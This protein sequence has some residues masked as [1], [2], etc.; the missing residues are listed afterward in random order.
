MGPQEYLTAPAPS[1]T[2][3]RVLCVA[4]AVSLASCSLSPFGSHPA[5]FPPLEPGKGRVLLYRSSSSVSSYVSEALLNGERVGRA[6][7]KGVVYRD[8]APG[9]YAV[10]T[11]MT[12]RVV[13]F[14]VAAGER[15]YVRFS[16]AFFDS[17]IYP[18]LVEASKGE[19]ETAS[20]E[21]LDP[22]RTV[23]PKLP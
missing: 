15:K 2:M 14:S 18:E 16:N 22:P 12:A 17:R 10:T 21:R 6:D 20:L 1:A 11:T 9:S 8:V 4:A 13:N 3:L 7:R 19:S 23:P 5:P